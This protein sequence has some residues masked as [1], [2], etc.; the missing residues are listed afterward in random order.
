LDQREFQISEFGG[1]KDAWLKA[2]EARRPIIIITSNREKELPGPF[3]RRCFYHFI[4]FP[5]EPELKSILAAHVPDLK[6]TLREQVVKRFMAVRKN[7]EERTLPG[8]QV[9]TSE[10]I[11]WARALHIFNNEKEIEERLAA[12]EK[13]LSQTPH[14]NALFKSQEQFEAYQGK[15]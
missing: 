13:D 9:S 6:I 2:D 15:G 4:K 12:M 1:G 10:L 14:Q 3:L 11:D 7:M 5:E 8:K